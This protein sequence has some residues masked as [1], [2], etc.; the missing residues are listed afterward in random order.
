MEVT[1]RI[2]KV[3]SDFETGKILLSLEINEKNKLKNEYDRLRRYEKLS[4]KLDKFRNKRS[5][6][7]NGYMWHLCDE[8]AKVLSDTTADKYTKDDIYIRAIKEIGIFKTMEINEEAVDT[9]IHSWK[10][11]GTGWVVEKVDNGRYEGFVIIRLYYGSSTYT[12]KQMSRLINN[13]VQDCKAVG[14]ETMTPKEIEE[15]TSLWKP[16][17]KYCSKR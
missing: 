4:I 7:A 3:T 12:T 5:R 16:D 1:G 2:D 11:H 8:L 6:D 9:A 17:A 13:I 14:I 10:L 15:L